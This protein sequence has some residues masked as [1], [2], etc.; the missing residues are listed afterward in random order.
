M[1]I[2]IVAEAAM[3]HRGN[4][5]KAFQLIHEAREAGADTIKF[6]MW[7]T[8]Q[9]V[10]DG[11]PLH[12]IFSESELGKED[13]GSINQF[14]KQSGI[15]FLVTPLDVASLDFLNTELMCERFKVASGDITFYPLLKR[16]QQIGKPVI[17]SVG[18]AALKE[19]EVALEILRDIPV[20]LTHCTMDYPCPDGDVNL[21]RLRVLKDLFPRCNIGLSDH[22]IDGFASAIAVPLG[23]CY[24]EK[25]LSFK[26][27]PDGAVGTYGFSEYATWIRRA[28]SMMGR[29]EFVLTKGERV[30]VPQARRNEE[31]W[32]REVENAH[33]L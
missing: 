28:E 27:E 20:T 1:A 15:R 21:S 26:P 6:Q 9:F 23:I 4:V 22:T 10:A 29:Q 19:I 18:G 30:W 7:H 17:L 13:W 25:H 2:E 32:R 12:H 24:A 3:Y 16:L 31:T 33:A 11:H 5:Y 8:D 14:A